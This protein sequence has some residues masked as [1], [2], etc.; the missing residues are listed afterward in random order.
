M[1]DDVRTL[2]AFDIEALQDQVRRHVQVWAR[3]EAQHWVEASEFDEFVSWKSCRRWPTSY[4]FHIAL[5]V[6]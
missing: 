4:G 5:L 6:S 2:R 1:R 3:G